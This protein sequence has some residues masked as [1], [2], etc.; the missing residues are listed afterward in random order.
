M[1]EVI[2]P[3]YLNSWIID[4]HLLNIYTFHI[5]QKIIIL[6]RLSPNTEQS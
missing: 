6:L 2:A 3:E 4:F 5:F 1:D